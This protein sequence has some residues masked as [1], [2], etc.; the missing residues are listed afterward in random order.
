MNITLSF[1]KK[2]HEVKVKSSRRFDDW[3]KKYDRSILQSLVFRN[4]HE[5]F[6]RQIVSDKTISRV[7]DI[8]CGTGELALKL[9]NYRS[10]IDISGIDISSNM[11][12]IAKTKAKFDTG[13]DFRVGDVEHMPYEDNYFDCITCAH[14]FHHYP[15]KRKAIREMFRVLKDEGKVMIVDG[16]KDGMVGK[17]IF[18]F[19]IKKH[20]INVHHLHS[21]Q[22]KRI[23]GR[24]GFTDISQT[25]FNPLIPLLFTKGVAKK[26]NIDSKYSSY[27]DRRTFSLENV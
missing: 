1:I 16:C 9:K 23:M 21:R 4:S 11:I 7:L 22:F 13:I 19:I 6:I 8:G 17:F 24:V 12:N 14:S 2:P 25:V 10:D 18:D 15:N 20:E 26:Q 5:M 27:L 3:A